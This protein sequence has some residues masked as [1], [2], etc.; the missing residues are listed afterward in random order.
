[1]LRD[2]RNKHKQSTKEFAKLLD[3]DIKTYYKYEQQDR[4]IPV[5]KALIICELF[6]CSLDE[7]YK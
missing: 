6:N 5:K 3:V 4:I 7:I 2:V 1:M